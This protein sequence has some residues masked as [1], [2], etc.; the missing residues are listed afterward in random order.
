VTERSKLSARWIGRN[1]RF[2]T[3]QVGNR[4]RQSILVGESLQITARVHLGAVDPQHV[5]AEAYHVKWI[6]D[7]AAVIQRIWMRGEGAALA[8]RNRSSNGPMA[9]GF[10]AL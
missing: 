5:R 10:S 4:D 8:T 6:S 9:I 2:L 7:A 1:S 3:V